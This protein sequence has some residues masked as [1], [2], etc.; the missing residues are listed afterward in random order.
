MNIFVKLSC[1]IDCP[2]ANKQKIL[3]TYWLNHACF[4]V[5]TLA[6][7]ID[8][9]GFFFLEKKENNIFVD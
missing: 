7:N 6:M 8:I 1:V 9:S 4:S 2:D 3:N 5:V